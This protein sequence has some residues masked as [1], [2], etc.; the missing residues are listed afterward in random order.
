[1]RHWGRR[2][3]RSGVLGER[4]YCRLALATE[5]PELKLLQITLRL[6][7]PRDRPTQRRRPVLL[8]CLPDP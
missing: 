8:H 2:E 1:M 6:I 3:A 4:C 7:E 5:S